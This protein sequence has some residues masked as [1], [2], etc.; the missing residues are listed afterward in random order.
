[1]KRDESRRRLYT[2]DLAKKKRML[3]SHL[4]DELRAVK[5]SRSALVA[6][7]DTVKVMRGASKGKT[8]KVAKV[9]YAKQ[10]VYI[11]GIT[12]KNSRGVESLIAFHPSNLLLTLKFD[13]KAPKA[14]VPATPAAAPAAQKAPAQP[15]AAPSEAKV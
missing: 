7:G 5:K 14:A 11:E 6:K 10:A 3:R 12:R 9:S 13:S 15:A 2:A 4:S 8:G 1:M